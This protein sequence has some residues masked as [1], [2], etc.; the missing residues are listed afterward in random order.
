MKNLLN[1]L[2][3]YYQ[4]ARDFFPSAVPIGMTDFENWSSS[5]IST[6][7]FPD[8]D[9][10]RF[11]LASQVMHSGDKAAFTPRRVFMLMLRAGAAKQVA[12]AVFSDLKA[13]QQAA[14]A[15][16]VKPV[17]VTTTPVTSNESQ[18]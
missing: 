6:Y 18:G 7:N 10:I 15:E 2:K 5:I 14:A 11:A 3:R 1:N 12:Y 9:S 8:N 16:Q 13:K 17:E 4:I